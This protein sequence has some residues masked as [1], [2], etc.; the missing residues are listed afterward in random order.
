MAT[1]KDNPIRIL[2]IKKTDSLKTIYAKVRR[3]FTAADLARFADIDEKMFPADEL[4]KELEA[5][6]RE[7]KQ[8]RKRKKPAQAHPAALPAVSTKQVPTSKPLANGS[9]SKKTGRR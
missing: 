9:K 7:E 4:L 6:N 3:S 8:K 5:I 1:K 2:R